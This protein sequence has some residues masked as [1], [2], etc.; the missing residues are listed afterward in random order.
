[1]NE[2]EKLLPLL[3]F[4]R[5]QPA[6]AR[7]ELAR[8]S[9]ARTYPTGNILYYH[10]EPGGE[11]LLLLSGRVKLSMVSDDGREVVLALIRAP[12]A[13]GLD[14][15]LTRSTYLGTAVTLGTS[16]IAKIPA[17][18][19]AT[20]FRRHSE[21]QLE[22]LGGL[23]RDLRSAFGKIGEQA[24]L[25]VKERL[26]LELMEI[27]RADGKGGPDGEVAFVRPTM[28]E[29]ADR[30]G[31]SRVVVSRIMKEILEEETSMAAQGNVIRVYPK[32][33][34]AENDFGGDPPAGGSGALRPV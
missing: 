8:L 22:L 5:R 30:V 27:A 18:A 4:L 33:L 23:A 11:L 20:W 1:M 13:L 25:T 19:F 10:G 7:Q 21:V 29:L 6:A 28:Q 26:L 14:A 34:V 24:L 16:R 3:P 31:S 15:V 9:V 12:G 32:D 2:L 17:E